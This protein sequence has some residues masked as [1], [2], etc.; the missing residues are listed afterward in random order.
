[1]PGLFDLLSADDLCA[2]LEHDYA[3]VCTNAGDA[4]AAF[5]F[6]VTA[7]HLLEWRY[8][9]NSSQAQRD[10]IR[11]ANPII[12]LCEHLAVGGKHYEPTAKR[13][14]TVAGSRR[15]SL[16]K[17]GLWAPGL[18]APGFWQDD[19]IIELAGPAQMAFGDT[20]N[21]ARFAQLM[22][23]FWRTQGGCKGQRVPGS[24]T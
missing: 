14:R 23:E 2:K 9:G 18:W 16:W 6:V 5:D 10:A 3:R 20:M 19:L 7:W 12:E 21:F 17:R 8:P 24:A 11:E 4:Y 1:M 15:A 22:I 13:H